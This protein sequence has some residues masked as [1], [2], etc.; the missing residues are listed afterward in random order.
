MS[1]SGTDII[2]KAEHHKVSNKQER[3]TLPNTMVKKTPWSAAKVLGIGQITKGFRC[4]GET[5][6]SGEHH[7]PIRCGNPINEA[8]RE[9]AIVILEDLELLNPHTDYLDDI[10]YELADAL[11]CPKR[12]NYDHRGDQR[13]KQVG[14][15]KE[16]IAEYAR[17]ARKDSDTVMGEA[18][19][20][21]RSLLRRQDELEILVQRMSITRRE[22][23]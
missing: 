10:L 22:E 2:P 17:T 23:R 18:G 9:K 11:L 8:N 13:K 16:V 12:K 19:D 6:R 14:K 20:T 15:W 7:E 5:A 3:P 1:H 21:M 4:V